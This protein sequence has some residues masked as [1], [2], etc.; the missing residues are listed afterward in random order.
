MRVRM[1]PSRFLAICFAAGVAVLVSTRRTDAQTQTPSVG[2]AARAA[3]RTY[4]EKNEGAI[5]TEFAE[6]L[7]LPNLASDSTNIRR[8]ANHL[9]GML[10]KRGFVNT[11]LLTVPNAPPAVYGELPAPGA[12]RTLVLY[13]HYDG[14]PLEPKQWT[15]APR[16]PVLRTGEVTTGG[17]I[18]PIPGDGGHI[19][20]EARLYRSSAGDDKGSI[21][22]MLTALD[23]MRAAGVKPSVNIKVFF[24]GDEVAG[25]PHLP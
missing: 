9:L 23:A 8:N 22:T 25:A 13:A 16:S 4:R 3:A 10:G 18:I 19:D 11:R 2:V 12:S 21:I 15:S 1:L 5:V 24:E 14:Q 17:R 6:L 7:S 20:P